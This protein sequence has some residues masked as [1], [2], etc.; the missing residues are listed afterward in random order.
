MLAAASVGL[1]GCSGKTPPQ[2]ANYSVPGTYTYTITAT[3][4]FL[5]H[6]ATYSLTITAK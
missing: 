3:D 6:S 1:S 4:G 2:N 5:V